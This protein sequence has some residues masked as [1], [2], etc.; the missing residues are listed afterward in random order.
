MKYPNVILAKKGQKKSI[1]IE[2]E[3]LVS[4]KTENLDEILAIRGAGTFKGRAIFLS[5][6]YDY[7][8]VKDD[9]KSICLLI[10]EGR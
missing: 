1:I 10:L 6:E 2:E 7:V 8:L 4:P 5:S 9:L 3:R